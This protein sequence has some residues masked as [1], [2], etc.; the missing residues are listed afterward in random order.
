MNVRALL[1][2]A[3]AA[4]EAAGRFIASRRPGAVERK[5]AG[6]DS[7]ASQ[8]VT[9]VD[10]AS[11]AMIVEALEPSRVSYG[12][13]LLTE[14]RPDDGS[15]LSAPAFWCIDPLD[16]TLAYVEN[17]PGSSVCIALVARDG[18][19]LLGVVHDI[20][21]G[22]TLHGARGCGVWVGDAPWSSP[23]RGVNLRLFG[24]RSH[25]DDARYDALAQRL[26]ADGPLQVE[27]ARAAATNAWA[28]LEYAPGVY[29]KLPKPGRGGG[30]TW[31]F[32]ATA[33]IVQEAGGVATAFD[34]SPLRLNDPHTTFFSDTGVLFASSP[35]AAA[36]VQRASVGS[37]SF[38]AG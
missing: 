18:T 20:T 1:D 33:C 29:A 36:A 9:E 12:L 14:E 26:R 11:E 35:E 24:D 15:R 3:R 30:S 25:R 10:R 19:P 5:A 34:G 37:S 16:G 4:A 28:A 31:D 38:H 32:A 27:F 23:K 7:P 8:V 2:E 21:R 13:G 22:T 17:E 6:G